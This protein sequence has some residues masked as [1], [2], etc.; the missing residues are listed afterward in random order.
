[1]NGSRALATPA[2]WY[3]ALTRPGS[4]AVVGANDRRESFTGSVIPNLV[5]H[6]YEGLIY[7][8]NPGRDV[9]AG[10]QAF[11]SLD[12]LP[13][14]PDCVVSVVSAPI[15]VDV[16]GMA[17]ELGV[18]AGIVVASGFTEG[19]AGAEGRLR[20]IRLEEILDASEIRI[21]GPSTTGLISLVGGFVPR[22]ALNQVSAESVRS[23]PV[24]LI[25]QS[26]ACANIIYGRSQLAGL[27]IGLSVSTGLQLD[28]TMW[29]WL[30]EILHERTFTTVLLLI[31]DFGPA[32][33]WVPLLE[34]A[35]DAGVAIVVCRVGRTSAGALATQ[36]HTGAV[37]GDWEAEARLLTRLGAVHVDSLEGLWHVGA[38]CHA[39]GPP[40]NRSD[41]T[42]GVIAMSGGEGALVADLASD[43][44]LALPPV[45]ASV[46]AA[47]SEA[48]TLGA[49]ANPLDP[50]G[51][52]MG[53]PQAASIL[54]DTFVGGTDWSA[55]LV[56]APGL[57]EGLA[58]EVS[59]G[60][61]AKLIR[62]DR[63]VAVSG[64]CF[65]PASSS[66][67][68]ETDLPVF[69]RSSDAIRAINSYF[70]PR[71]G[72][73]RLALGLS[74]ANT[75]E[76]SLGDFDGSYWGSMFL[77]EAVGLPAPLR[78]LV[79]NLDVAIEAARDLGY[80][81][82]LKA[83]TQSTVHK[84]SRNLVVTA[85]RDEE[86]LIKAWATIRFAW[87]GDVA[88]ERHTLGDYEALLGARRSATM[89]KLAVFGAG[90]R[91]VEDR[92]DITV[93]PVDWVGPVTTDDLLETRI[94]QAIERKAPE[95]LTP[96]VASLNELVSFLGRSVSALEINPA[97][98]TLNLGTW[99][100]LDCR[101]EQVPAIGEPNGI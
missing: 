21:L 34:L 36:T 95:A 61:L 33:T 35:R 48:M 76:R 25:A 39:W 7:P 14:I 12:A 32:T 57:R 45:P 65:D 87:T 44:G 85:V 53:S 100:A 30:E 27:P 62:P 60:I 24:A 23:G 90:G 17:A 18:K 68:L 54:A 56:A 99:T 5:A 96:I 1:M 6:G 98:F 69:P 9:V 49:P 31:E 82:V 3:T 19:G 15:A 11:P 94:G 72:S 67:L 58:R 47:L 50:T 88:V 13:Q 92:R 79:S 20:T 40:P 81:L 86:A 80:P 16:I 42:L 41:R 83:N 93:V 66:V 71:R 46:A 74:M 51:A 8:V 2:P 37:A 63:S 4:V 78:R 84:A 101:I 77:A 55:Y 91:Q 64:W 29:D 43:C 89:G 73:H 70:A 59:A 75:H 10:L 52:V 26:G 28:L 22:A 38:L 97:M